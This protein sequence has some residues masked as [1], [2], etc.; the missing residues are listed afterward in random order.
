[1]VQMS[2]K[3]W[4]LIVLKRSF[5]LNM[6]IHD[7]HISFDPYNIF[8]WTIYFNNNFTTLKLLA[9]GHMFLVKSVY[10]QI[11][12]QDNGSMNCASHRLI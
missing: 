7:M 11:N 5:F 2:G 6:L 4:I 8:I 12:G 10:T 9:M 1:M 3:S